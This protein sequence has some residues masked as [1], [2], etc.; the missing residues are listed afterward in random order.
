M[1]YLTGSSRRITSGIPSF[2]RAGPGFSRED[3]D[4]NVLRMAYIAGESIKH[5]DIAICAP[6]APYAETR[7]QARA[8]ISEYGQF[9]EIHLATPRCL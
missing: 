1:A 5:G 7:R 6:I 2:G 8:L 9:I 4:R 3:R